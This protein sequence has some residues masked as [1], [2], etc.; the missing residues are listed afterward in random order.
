MNWVK[1]FYSRQAQWL[2]LYQGA[3]TDEHRERLGQ[4][5]AWIGRGPRR[6]LELG[7]GGGE[8]AAVMGQ[9]G[10]RVTAIELLQ[11]AADRGR[12]L[13]AA[14]APGMVDMVCGDF[15]TVTV[16]GPFDLVCYWDGFGVGSD[17]Q[18]R[19][20]LRRI[21]NW[22][23][24]GGAALVE[25]YTPWYAAKQAGQTRTVGPFTRT[26]GFDV[27]QCRWLDTW[28]STA[29]AE[30]RVCQS[31]RCYS[32]ADLRLLLR[33]TGLALLDLKPAA[34]E[35]SGTLEEAYAYTARLVAA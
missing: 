32:P 34:I 2:G 1:E 29:D 3:V 10:H 12:E 17:D 6:I 18:Q 13:S 5:E 4:V 28:F 25:V 30:D 8:V 21:A 35:S 9:A 23:A 22:L 20:L 19:L 15:Y 7:A 26:L 24:P 27:E 14:L 11:A 16:T 31:L 33:E